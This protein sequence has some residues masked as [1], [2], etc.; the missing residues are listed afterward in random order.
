MIKKIK[1]ELIYFFAIVFI[2][3]LLQ[4]PDLLS[5]PLE[6]LQKMHQ[7]Q[8]YLHPLMWSFIIYAVLGIF[9]AIIG[10][11]LHIKNKNK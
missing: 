1:I 10:F 6:R 5:S 4:H 2:L 11:V 9:R 8:N 7:A 3:A